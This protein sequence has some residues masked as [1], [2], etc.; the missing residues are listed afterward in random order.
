MEPDATLPGAAAGGVLHP[1]TGEHF[2]GAVVHHHRHRHD[3][4]ALVRAQEAMH[5][6]IQTERLRRRIE[7][8]ERAAEELFARVLGAADLHRAHVVNTFSTSIV[9]GA[10]T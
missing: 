3:E 4:R 8:S 9:G 2:E 6:G 10:M 1:V 5:A 7:L